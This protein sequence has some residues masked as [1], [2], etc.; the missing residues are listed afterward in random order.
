MN[1]KDFVRSK[2]KCEQRKKLNGKSMKELDKKKK[3]DDCK[4][5]YSKYLIYFFV[6][7]LI[8][9]LLYTCSYKL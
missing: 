8:L 5:I 1:K 3:I 2:Q 9:N 6:F 7:Y 4:Y